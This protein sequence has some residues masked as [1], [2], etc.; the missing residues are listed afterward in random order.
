MIGESFRRGI[1]RLLLISSTDLSTIDEVSN[2]VLSLQSEQLVI[3]LDKVEEE[4]E[5]KCVK[6]DNGE[7]IATLTNDGSFCVI[8][9]PSTTTSD[10]AFVTPPETIEATSVNS[11]QI[12]EIT[13]LVKHE[14]LGDVPLITEIASISKQE[15]STTNTDAARN[16]NED[17]THVEC[18]LDRNPQITES[19]HECTEPKSDDDEETRSLSHYQTFTNYS[20]YAETPTS[21]Q[22]AQIAASITANAITNA[23]LGQS[24]SSDIDF[25]CVDTTRRARIVLIEHMLRV[26]V[27]HSFR[28]HPHFSV[29]C[30]WTPSCIHSLLN[31]TINGAPCAIKVSFFPYPSRQGQNNFFIFFTRTLFGIKSERFDIE[32][33]KEKKTRKIY[34]FAKR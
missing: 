15:I 2:E 11:G 7:M 6:G 32:R 24:R 10:D 4:G 34:I 12:S 13:S 14:P 20:N 16:G 29:V 1:L 18:D 33:E 25:G 23:V 5:N 26:S 22:T 28:Y 31:L 19:N 3:N 30:F 17:S 27:T 8:E 9:N 21:E